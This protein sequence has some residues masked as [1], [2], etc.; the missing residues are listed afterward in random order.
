MESGSIVMGNL[1]V[2]DADETEKELESSSMTESKLELKNDD[3]MLENNGVKEQKEQKG[4]E[5]GW[6]QFSIIISIHIN[7][8]LTVLSFKCTYLIPTKP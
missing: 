6:F 4:E 2:K 5:Q 8:S 3:S 7:R 1:N